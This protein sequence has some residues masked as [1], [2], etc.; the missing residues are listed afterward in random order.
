MA[1]PK[2]TSKEIKNIINNQ[3]FIMEEPG[4]GEP[5][6]PLMGVH[7]ANSEYD[8]SLEKLRLRN[9]VIGDLQNK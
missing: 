1:W 7:K 4:K 2:G 3:T 5:V 6:T 9:V 8:G